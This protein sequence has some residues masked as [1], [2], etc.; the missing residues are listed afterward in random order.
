MGKIRRRHTQYVVFM[1][2]RPLKRRF[3]PLLIGGILVIAGA[4]RVRGEAANSST[5]ASF[6]GSNGNGP[7]A[8]LLKSA[9]GNFYGT[10]WQGGTNGLPLGLGT[11]FKLDP[12]GSLTTLVSFSGDNGAKPSA[13]LIQ[14][15][16]GNLYGTTWQ[17]GSSNLGTVFRVTTNG[18]LTT[19]LSFT[20]GNGAKPSARLTLGGDGLLYG[21]TQSG[22]A[23]DKGT[24]F[25]MTTNGLLT[26][27]QSFNTTNGAKPNA[28]IIQGRDGSFYGTTV[29]GGLLDAGT[30]FRVTTNGTLTT[31]FSF[32]DTN[33]ANPYGGLAQGADG[34]LYGTTAYGGTKGYGIIFRITTNGSLTTMHT[35]T[36]G[37]DGA[38][39]WSSLMR[40]IDDTFYGTTILGGPATSAGTWG[41]VFQIATNGQFSSLASFG[42]TANGVSPYG[43]LVQDATGD[44]YGTTYSGGTGLRGTV[45]RLIPGQPTLAAALQPPNSF[46]LSWGAWLGKTYQVQ[47][48][49]NVTQTGW[50]DFGNTLVATNGTTTVNDAT[51]SPARFYRVRLLVTP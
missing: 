1:A 19:L 30:V 22:G 49:T 35:F 40:G 4:V 18:N 11:I 41:T 17:G 24:V 6:A 51:S 3:F 34:V 50:I 28:N 42:F 7:Y 43:S 32:G 37:D 8:G 27:L 36:G 44:L 5:L 10:T 2:L 39:P 38:N 13:A 33:G 31:L 15:P 46:R 48:R 26:T 21:T 47:Y 9:D 25:R 45:F 20:N 12:A 16:D 23:N 29:N 14:T